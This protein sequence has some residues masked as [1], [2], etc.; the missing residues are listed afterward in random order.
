[1]TLPHAQQFAN[2]TL[3]RAVFADPLAVARAI[4]AGEAPQL[5]GALWDQTGEQLVPIA[6]MPNTGFTAT[7]ERRGSYTMIM[8]VPPAPRV[9]GDAALIAI[10]ARG[11]GVTKMLTVG[12]Y[13]LELALDAERLPRFEMVSRGSAD[14]K[15]SRWTDGP[16]PDG[17]WFGANAFELYTGHTPMPQLGIP[18]LPF[19]WWWHGFDGAGALRVFTDAKDE[20]ERFDAVRAAPILLLPEIAD[21]AAIFVDPAPAERLR[22]LRPFL[23]KATSLASAW[24]DV[25]RRL[26]SSS[27]GNAPANTLR[28]LPLI[29]EAAK[30]GSLT[31]AQGFELESSVRGRLAALGVSRAENLE[32]AERLLD[33]ARTPRPKPASIPPLF[34]TEDPVWLP[35]FLDESDLPGHLR[36]ERDDVRMTNDPTFLAHRGVRAGYAVWGSD[37]S[38][39][40]ARIIDTRWVF[41]TAMFAHQFMR[42]FA[43]LLADGLP[44]LPAPILGDDVLAFGDQTVGNRRSHVI[45]TRIGRVV[46]R[47]QATEGIYAAASR[48]VLHAAMLHPLGHKIVQR[49]QRG[50]AAYW[51]AVAYPTNAVP[52]L[53][54]SKG[55]DAAQLLDKYPL[56]AHPELPGAMSTFD[57]TYAEAA[58]AL[59]NFQ[60]QVRA[61][62]WGTYRQAMMRLVRALLDSDMGD[63]RVNAA[64]AHEIVNELRYLDPDPIWTQLDAEC[65]ARG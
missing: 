43:H 28:T 19:W 4:D 65:Q 59:A 5:L 36:G 18:E 3:P 20:T 58:A 60:A 55:H 22:E 38:S 34:A 40:M 53:L 21:A 9:P 50:L 30:H 17:K 48:Q 10:I 7:I 47:V 44:A 63:A 24:Q 57:E 1:M 2:H 42:S 46:A 11:D 13:V 56:L 33:A 31:E 25:V 35:L 29:A 8:I 54:H 45:F 12:Y 27:L 37:E 64:H 52:A 16:L 6:R 61:H 15:G 39:A 14:D 32:A 41:R 23:L 51:L 26:A 49:A 62:R